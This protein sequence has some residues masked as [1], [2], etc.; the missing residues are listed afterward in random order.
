MEVANCK[1]YRIVDADR[2]AKY[3]VDEELLIEHN[4]T[5]YYSPNKK[6]IEKILEDNRPNNFQ[7]RNEALF[8]FPKSKYDYE[9]V[10]ANLKYN[11]H[12][13]EYLLLELELTGKLYWL[14]AG[15]YNN[16][17][18]L[19]NIFSE[20]AEKSIKAYWTEIQ[21]SDFTENMDIEGLFTGT[22]IIKKIVR[23]KHCPNGENIEID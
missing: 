20:E 10:W 13:K 5:G 4:N 18:S 15:I 2:G 6:T 3:K 22:A 21:E 8:V 17:I 16:S 11:H 14:N 7:S 1:A 19:Q 9:S 12:E 23:K